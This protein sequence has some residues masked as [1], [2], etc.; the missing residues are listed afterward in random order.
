MN[1]FRMTLVFMVVKE[2]SIYQSAF[3]LKKKLHLNIKEKVVF[4][5]WPAFRHHWRNVY[6]EFSK[7]LGSDRYPWYGIEQDILIPFLLSMWSDEGHISGKGP[8]DGKC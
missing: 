2:A 3:E 1:Y 4:L 6:Y 5:V 7:G 8:W